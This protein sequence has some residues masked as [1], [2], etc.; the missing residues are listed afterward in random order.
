MS[1][2]FGQAFESYTQ[3]LTFSGGLEAALGFIVI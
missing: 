2:R 3:G 1:S